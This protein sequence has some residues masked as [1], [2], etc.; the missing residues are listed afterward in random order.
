[1][2]RRVISLTIRDRKQTSLVRKQAWVE[3]SSNYK[4]IIPVVVEMRA[5]RKDNVGTTRLMKWLP[6]GD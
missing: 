6:K 2:E 4:K 1:M 5:W 3:D